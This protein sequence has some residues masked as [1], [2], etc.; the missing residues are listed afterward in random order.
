[1]KF[2]T[3]IISEEGFLEGYSTIRVTHTDEEN[4]WGYSQIIPDHVIDGH[5]LGPILKDMKTAIKE[6]VLVR[7]K[8]ES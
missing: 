1:M 3:V 5:E 2:V 7:E 6:K 4:K 8:E